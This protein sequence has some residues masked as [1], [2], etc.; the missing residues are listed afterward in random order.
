MNRRDFLKGAAVG[1]ASIL[2]PS[3][4]KVEA[5]DTAKSAIKS[6]REIG[7]TG[8]KM[9]D[10]S[11]GGGQLT[12]SAMIL[13]AVDKGINYFDTAPDYGESENTIGEAMSKLPREKIIIASKFCNPLKYPAHL[14]AGTPVKDYIAAVDASLTRLK[15]NYLDF[16]FVHAIGE[17][18]QDVNAETARLLDKN[19]LIAVDELKAQKKIKYLATSS[20]G[21][22]NMEELLTRAI[23]SGHYA[24]V[25]GSYN[26]MDFPKLPEVMKHAKSK[27]V[28]FIA[29]KTMAGAK[30]VGIETDGLTFS[31]AAFKW[32]LKHEEVSGL[33]VTIKNVKELEEY[34]QASGQAFT[35]SDR[36]V[37]ERYAANYSSS[38][39]RTGCDQCEGY[40]AKGVEVGAALRYHMYF[41][42]YGLEKRAIESYATLLVNAKECGD[43]DDPKCA[44][45]CPF[46]VRVKHM[47][48]CAHR[49]LT[50]N[51]G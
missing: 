31:N 44:A 8:L 33:I 34:V 36:E 20:H 40:C 19:M 23:D 3:I 39:C 24:M 13:R 10:I 9:S 43:C 18:N 35:S 7:T 51:I 16:C 38:Y 45:G 37:L 28:G 4:L 5:S 2:S 15:T 50:V 17:M 32:V 29:M 14:K 41:R 6:Y 26:F 21:P 46:G 49:D 25:M 48:S 1:T 47:L 22:H 11:F 12:S 42:D 27:G 30:K